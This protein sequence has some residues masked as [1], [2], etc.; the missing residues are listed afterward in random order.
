MVWRFTFFAAKYAEYK[1]EALDYLADVA[2][3]WVEEKL[4]EGTLSPYVDR[5]VGALSL[6]LF[7]LK[8]Y[9]SYS[10]SVPEFDR[11]ISKHT[12]E[13]NGLFGNFFTSALAA[14]GLCGACP[15]SAACPKLQQFVGR[16]IAQHPKETFNDAKN[17]A[18]AYLVSKERGDSGSISL[19]VQESRRKLGNL[20]LPRSERLFPGF[21]L[22]CEIN[23]LG[24]EER[25]LV[26]HSCQ[27]SMDFVRTYSV[28]AT[29]PSELLSQYSS[30]ASASASTME[31]NGHKSRPRLSRI[32]LSFSLVLLRLYEKSQ[33]AFLTREARLQSVIRG[34][35]YG[36]L[37]VGI[38]GG[39]FWL[40]A[41]GGMPYDLRTF[42]PAHP[43]LLLVRLAANMAWVSA[44]LLPL[45]PAFIFIDRL[46]LRRQGTGEISL[47]RQSWA[48]V[49]KHW[50]L[51]ILLA[52]A[53]ASL[54]TLFS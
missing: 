7:T 16:E 4:K 41:E 2:N 45:F 52:A 24:R 53:L 37:W 43:V 9:C 50:A 38:S 44:I 28:E 51:K 10:A 6:F 19:L 3:L 31:A 12:D 14:L 42:Y 46:V 15:T 49:R 22:L 54:R 30:D 47:L 13:N 18:V 29:Y 34:T 40:G 5:D 33:P 17:L 21:V 39:L 36:T 26:K 27:E 25:L 35:V 1:N 32:L 8:R 20:A 23:Q 11:L 48:S